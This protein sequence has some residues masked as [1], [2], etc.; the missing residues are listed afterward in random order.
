MS[1]MIL[2]MY[3]DY[4]AEAVFW[5]L[6]QSGLKVLK[7]TI[8]DFP[9]EQGI[10]MRLSND[11][12]S[13]GAVDWSE[14]G[15]GIVG[16]GR[17]GDPFK[18][19]WNRRIGRPQ[20]PRHIKQ[21]DRPFINSESNIAKRGVINNIY[22][23]CLWVNSPL[24]NSILENKI[25]QLMLAKKVG[26]NIP[27]TIVTNDP[28]EALEFCNNHDRTVY[29][30]FNAPQWFSARERASYSTMT[31]LVTGGTLKELEQSLKI[32]PGIFQSYMEKKYELRVTVM[33]DE[34]V[35]AK[36]DSQ[37]SE[38]SSIDWRSGMFGC[39]VEEVRLPAD[40]YVKI[41]Q[42]MREAGLVF[43][44]IDLVVGPSDE[45]TFLEVNPGGQFLWVESFNPEI[46]ML[47]RFCNFLIS[48]S[49]GQESACA[50]SVNIE[51]FAKTESS[52]YAMEQPELRKNRYKSIL[53]Y[54]TVHRE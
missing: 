18:L 21:C 11:S 2:S 14:D 16:D 43:G 6:Q 34:Y 24:N 40:V 53:Q 38:A 25:T 4:H 10:S 39:E 29:K 32:C 42:F 23:D 12:T 51:A 31:T 22:Q 33:G 52:A 7:W 1:I 49:G 3:L 9:A 8:S 36:L 46:K 54:N 50:S 30:A 47:S 48:A 17:I 26:L 13:V 37:A 41:K 35:A 28:A 44:C 19:I 27:D 45:Y 20:I 5:G 15:R